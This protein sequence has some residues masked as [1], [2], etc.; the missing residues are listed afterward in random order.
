VTYFS[1]VVLINILQ[2]IHSVWKKNLCRMELSRNR[3]EEFVGDLRRGCAIQRFAKRRRGV[4]E[5]RN[6]K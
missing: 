6:I 1:P 3:L 2:A 5:V 4:C